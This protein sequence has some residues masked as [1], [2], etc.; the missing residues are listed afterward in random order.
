MIILYISCLHPVDT[1]EYSL[2]HFLGDGTL[3]KCEIYGEVQYRPWESH[4]I[5]SFV[6]PDGQFRLMSYRVRKLKSIPLYLKPQLTSDAGTCR[7]S[8]LVGMRNDPGKIV[9]SIDVQ[10]QLPPCISTA[11][12]SSN[13]GT[14]NILSNK[15]FSW[16][17]GRIPKDK[18]PSLS[19]NAATALSTPPCSSHHP[20]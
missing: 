4:Q 16:S 1:D 11:D 3:F 7:L 9:D 12:L 19:K 6:P 20:H 18:T 15:T 17:I 8:L 10:F 13:C 5:L 2:M 14:V